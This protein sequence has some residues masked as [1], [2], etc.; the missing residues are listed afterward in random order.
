MKQ[1]ELTKSQKVAT[2]IGV[3]LGV[4]LSALDSTI[5]GTAMPRIVR[6]LSGM[7]LYAWPFT[8]YMLLSTLAL[9]I[10][11]K[12]ADL[13]GQKPVFLTGL[14]VFI[15]S[16]ALCGFSVNMPMLIVLRGLQGIGGGILV[17]NSFSIVAEIYS[18]R[19]RGKYMGLLA[20]MFGLSS[21]VGPGFGGF[22]T[23]ILGWQW[24]FYVNIPIGLIAIFLIAFG[25]PKAAEH[26][27]KKRIDVAGILTLICGISPLLL[28]LS[29]G[30]V[31]FEWFSLPILGLFGIAAVFISLFLIAE[32]HATEPILPL[33][34]FQ[35]PIFSL[36]SLAAF[37]ANAAFFCG[38]LFLPLYLQISL[39]VSAT[40][41]G[42]TILPMMLS[43]VIGSILAGQI[44]SAMGRYK[45]LS[46]TGMAVS[47]IGLILLATLPQH[48]DGWL[49]TLG[50]VL[51]GSGLGVNTPIFNISVQN[52]F[53]QKYISLLTS[54]IQFFRNIGGAA[55]AA[56]LGSLLTLS[57]HTGA[58]KMD[59]NGIQMQYRDQM[60]ESRFFSNPQ[61]IE[62]VRKTIPD[63]AKAAY[64][65]AVGDLMKIV[66]DSVK[67][68]F[69][70]GA[71]FCLLSAA[72]LFFPKEVSLPPVSRMPIGKPD[73]ASGAESD[74]E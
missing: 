8:A 73:T 29:M 70:L 13:F 27:E 74:L 44:V 15:I 48:P 57:I 19:E 55:G 34:L 16:S 5:V 14:I 17:A 33:F 22:L 72:F 3:I 60:S 7:D 46:V 2:L 67:Q 10:F 51:M 30:G 36:T 64:D 58:Q 56:V 24:C 50:M 9:P 20:S 66:G 65:Q 63:S 45:T 18:I 31:Q 12:L 52:A 1:L 43:F 11:G 42:L 61:I 59:W 23:D 68:N 4:L 39:G 38:V 6:D 62:S 26:T 21:I 37:F 54:E 32:K 69:L 41:S 28:A 35:K 71:I 47:S 40:Q 49:L 25:L 53:P